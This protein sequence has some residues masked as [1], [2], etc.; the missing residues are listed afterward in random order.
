MIEVPSMLFQLEDMASMVDFFS[1]G[2]N[3][4]TQYL[5]A[6]D[7]N[8]PRVASLYNHYHPAVI[9][10]LHQ[11]VTEC[12]RLDRPVSICGEMAGDPAT[13]V[14]L[15]AMGFSALSMSAANLLKIRKTLCHISMSEAKNLLDEVLVM[16]SPAVIRS[17][18][19]HYMIKKGLADVVRPSQHNIGNM[20]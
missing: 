4:L 12:K 9:R 14:L 15:S 16:D 13:A 20:N 19:E 17:W 5:L 8:N 10:A 6:V 2:S 18:V 3:D 1:V 11:I 7:R